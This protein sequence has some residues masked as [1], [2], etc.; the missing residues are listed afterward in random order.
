MSLSLDHLVIRVEDLEQTITDFDSLGFTV[1]RGGTHADGSTHNALIGLADG[2]YFELIAFLKM[3]P[4]IAGG[5]RET[6]W[7]MASSTLRCGSA[8]LQRR[9]TPRMDAACVTKVPSTADV[10]GP[11]AHGSNGSWANRP[12]PICRSCVRH[13]ATRIARRARRRAPTPERSARSGECE[14]RGT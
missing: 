14:H 6:P 10:S 1:Q 4:S 9:S 11:M 3:R 8:Q 12:R 13:H 5:I 2:S 7:A